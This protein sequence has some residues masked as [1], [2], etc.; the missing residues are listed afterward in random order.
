MINGAVYNVLDYGADPTGV[1]VSTTAI[2]AAINAAQATVSGGLR[3]GGVIYFPAGLY[4]S[5]ELTVTAQFISFKGDGPTASTIIS[6]GVVNPLLKISLGSLPASVI[7]SPSFIRDL[8]FEG[9]GLANQLLLIQN[10]AQYRVQNCWFEGDGVTVTTVGLD[11]S[12]IGEFQDCIIRYATQFGLHIYQSAGSATTP[13]II[14]FRSC[15]FIRGYTFG[16][17]VENGTQISFYDCDFSA[18]GDAATGTTSV[19]GLWVVNSAPDGVGPGVNLYGCWFEQN[20]GTH[21]RVDQRGFP[22]GATNVYN[23]CFVNAAAS[24]CIY[25]SEPTVGNRTTVNVYN[26]TFA[27]ALIADVAYSA[28]TSGNFVNNSYSTIS[29]DATSNANILPF[30]TGNSRSGADLQSFGTLILTD[31]STTPSVIRAGVYLASNTSA[32]SITDFI[33]GGEG[34][35]LIVNATNGNTTLVNS[36]SLRLAGATNKTMAT[37]DVIQ[38]TRQNSVWYQM[39]YSTN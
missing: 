6:S 23:S 15:Q 8:K 22:P 35:V 5:G 14:T 12:I 11:S 13:N 17:K 30:T 21:L 2:Q 29:I 10:V 9:G 37:R 28:S 25:A 39:S 7:N 34:Q 31:N 26:S 19:G 16:A 33:N 1:L 24:Y 3:G 27:N 18:N 32:T 36:A 4:K 38:L 20:I